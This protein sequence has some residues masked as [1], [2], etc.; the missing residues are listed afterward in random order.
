MIKFF[1]LSLEVKS[2]IFFKTTLRMACSLIFWHN[3]TRPLLV[4]KLLFLLKA[5]SIF[6]TAEVYKNILRDKVIQKG[7]HYAWPMVALNDQKS[8]PLFANKSL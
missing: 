1:I 7:H 6:I 2:A 5:T 4:K 8:I 3:V